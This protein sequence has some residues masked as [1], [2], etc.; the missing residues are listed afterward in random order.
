MAA[1]VRGECQEDDPLTLILEERSHAVLA[2][3]RSHSEGIEVDF[4]EEGAG[5]HCAGV[6]DVAA[7]GICDD[8]VLWVVLVEVLDGLLKRNPSLHA[9][10]LIESEVGFVSHTIGCGGIN[11]CLV[12]GKDGVFLLQQML[13][14]LLDVGVETHTEEGLLGENLIDKFLTCHK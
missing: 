2:H 14:N 10:A 12:E 4:F 3:I 9:H 1:F 7:L 11:N 5:I 8:E 13:W 6:A